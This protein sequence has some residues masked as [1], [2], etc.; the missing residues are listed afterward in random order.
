MYIKYARCVGLLLSCLYKFELHI[1]SAVTPSYNWQLYCHFTCLTVL[2]S[3][4]IS[5]ISGMTMCVIM[6]SYNEE[7]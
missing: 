5:M 2:I 3:Q 1:Y 6:K 7:I 4:Y